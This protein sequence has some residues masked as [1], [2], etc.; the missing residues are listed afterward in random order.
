VSIVVH[1]SDG[2]NSRLV[3]FAPGSI[4]GEAALFDGNKRSAS[5]I[6]AEDAVVY[7]LSRTTLA[8]LAVTY[9]TLANKLLFNLGRHLSARLRQTTASL[10]EVDEPLR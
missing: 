6:A 4:F 1:G 2:A 7:S 10:R 5:A 8:A 3:T 9:P